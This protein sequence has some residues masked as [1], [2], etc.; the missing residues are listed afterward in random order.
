MNPNDYEISLY[1]EVCHTQIGRLVP[2]PE[3]KRI[4]PRIQ[5]ALDDHAAEKHVLIQGAIR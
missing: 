5:E 1:C 4:V 3:D 2:T